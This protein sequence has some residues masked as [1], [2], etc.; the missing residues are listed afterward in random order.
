MSKAPAFPPVQYES[1]WPVQTVLSEQGYPVNSCVP[2]EL[3]T[4]AATLKTSDG[5]YL[6]TLVLGSG[7]DGVLLAHE[8]GYS[9]CS[10]L[11]MGKELAEQGYWSC[12]LNI[13]LMEPRSS[14][15]IRILLLRLTP[16][17]R[18]RSWSVKAQ[19]A[20]FWPALF[21]EGRLPSF[22][23]SGKHCPFSGF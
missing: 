14:P 15:R 22:R 9:I 7:S 2:E 6:Y 11:D 16:K 1:A 19:S 13:G 4:H 17:P 21:A 8:Q 20:F 23:E 3:L 12:F 10:F 18:S 5:K